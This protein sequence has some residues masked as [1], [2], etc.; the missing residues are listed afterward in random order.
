MKTTF[1]LIQLICKIL[2]WNPSLLAVFDRYV[3]PNNTLFH[4]ME[5]HSIPTAKTRLSSRNSIPFENKGQIDLL[6]LARKLWPIATEPALVSGKSDS[7]L[8]P[9]KERFLVGLCRSCIKNISHWRC[10]PASGVFYHKAIDVVSM[11]CLYVY[12][13]RYP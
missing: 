3:H 10:P 4:S 6:H 9:G 7:L 12:V 13:K 1:P 2:H 11:A 8:N 5:N